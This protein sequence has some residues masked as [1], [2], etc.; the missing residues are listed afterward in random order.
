MWKQR[1]E[2]CY[3]QETYYYCIGYIKT[4]VCIFKTIY[5]YYHDLKNFTSLLPNKLKDENILT[6]RGKWNKN[7]GP[8]NLRASKVG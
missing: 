8:Y 3:F 1:K 6:G 7:Q 2:L 4:F 5:Y